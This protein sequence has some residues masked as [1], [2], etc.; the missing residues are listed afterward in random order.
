MKKIVAIILTLALTVAAF[1][2]CGNSKKEENTLTLY[3]WAGMFPQEMFD[4]FEEKTGVTVNLV[5]FDFDET[6]LAKLQ[7]EKGGTYDLI[8][9]DDY[10]IE[11]AIAE[12]LVKNLE[13]DK[14]SNYKSI[15]PIYQK[16]FFDPTDEYSVPLA[17]GI[18]TIVYNPETAPKKIESYAD[19]WDSS[20]ADSI[21]ITSNLRV[22]NGMALKI[23]DE[24]YNTE[25]LDKIAQ[26]GEKLKE[27][28]PNI[29]VIKEDNLQNDLISGEISA[30]VMYTSQVTKA[31]IE[32]PS[33]EVV[34]PKE[35]LGLGIISQFIPVN[36]PNS[37]AAYKFIDYLLDPEVA[38]GYYEYLGYYSTNK[39]ADSLIS[40]EYKEFLT[41]PSN[42]STDDM[43]MIQ[44]V[45]AEVIEEHEKIWTAFKNETE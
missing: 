18:Q 25:D 27:L 15:N 20:L 43:E 17:A 8:I 32:M 29:R 42:V 41:L 11:M 31:K 44:L 26:A 6:M 2:A 40:D 5:T 30:A 1:T 23:L 45:P 37:E 28:A 34:F 39:D 16:Q 7:T 14:I 21:G 4:D 13:T 35:G 33:L 38:A 3:T 9:A 12:G 19:L 10:I 24:S 22:I 36:A